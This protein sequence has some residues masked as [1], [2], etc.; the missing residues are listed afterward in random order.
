M[1]NFALY[2]Q[3]LSSLPDEQMRVLATGTTPVVETNGEE[4]RYVYRWPDLEVRC[5]VMPA[6]QLPEHL[7]GFVGYV[8]HIYQ[9]RIELDSRIRR[10]MRRILR[11]TLVVG[12]EIIPGRDEEGR[13]GEILGK[14]CHG[15]QPMVFHG[16]SILDHEGKVLVGGNGSYDLHA[17][18]DEGP[19]PGTPLGRWEKPHRPDEEEVPEAAQ[20]KARSLA[21]LQAEG[22]PLLS[23]LPVIETEAECRFRTQEEVV[24]RAIALCLVAVK[25]EG[26]DQETVENLAEHFQATNLFT[27]RERTF[28]DDANPTQHDRIQFA[29]RYECLQVMLWALGYADN[30]SRPD[31]ICD[32]PKAVSLLRDSGPEGFRARS[33]LRP[34]GEILDEADLI[35]RY[36]W[37]TTDARAKNQE[38]PAGLDS[39]VVVERHHALNWLIGYLGRDW[40]DVIT[41]T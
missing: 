5:N 27:P 35:Y 15:L 2:S 1:E 12:V 10:I 3:T 33:R 6:E 37:A 22:I 7:Q 26:L 41:D 40:D 25:G 34:A 16:N 20:R 21:R 17:F 4:L 39:G 18:I 29:W 36:A 14:F 32:V 8:A 38:T 9:G 24:D 19:E 30:L 11:T 23:T 31:H 13:A 28:I